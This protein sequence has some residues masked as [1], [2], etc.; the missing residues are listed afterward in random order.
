MKRI[1]TSFSYQ[2]ALTTLARMIFNS[3][4][5]M[6]YPF[7]PAFSRGSGLSIATLTQVIALRNFAGILSPVFSNLSNR[8]G[9][10]ATMSGALLLLAFAS[11]VAAYFPLLWLFG[12]SIILMGIAKTIFDPPVLAFIADAV[13]P[14]KRASAIAINE[15]AWAGGLLIGAPIAGWLIQRAGWKTPFIAIG[16]VSLIAFV[17]VWRTLPADKNAGKT[18]SHQP[19][20]SILRQHPIVWLACLVVF[21]LMVAIEG[22]SIIYGSW[23][24]DVFQLSVTNLGLTAI[25]IGGAEVCAEVTV[26]VTGNRFSRRKLAIFLGIGTALAYSLLPAIGGNIVGALVGLFLSFYFFE[27]F[28]VSLIP[29]NLE[30]VPTARTVVISLVLATSDIGRG[31]GSWLGHQVW[32]TAGIWGIGLMS[33]GIT[34]IAVV[35]LWMWIPDPT[36]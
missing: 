15:F 24:E 10:P 20:W 23:M 7:L 27:S 28:F 35:I 12:T 32:E 8:Y 25:L 30:L 3:A 11:F 26:G 1:F 2:L 29:L 17:L 34:L 13:P 6:V 14:Q 36:G 9:K 4:V 21:C 33:A 31:V 19:F 5:R 18:K 16:I 22:I